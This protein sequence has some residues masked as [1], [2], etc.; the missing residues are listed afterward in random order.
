MGISLMKTTVMTIVVL[1]AAPPAMTHHAGAMYDT[2]KRVVLTGTVKDFQWTNP[3]C[4]IQLLVPPMGSEQGA[5]DEWSIQMAAPVQVLRAGWK[6]HTLNPGD[7]IVV[8][9]HPMRDGKRAGDFVAATDG[10]GKTI[11]TTLA[12]AQP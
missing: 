12:G 3:H 1:A 8:T 7:K 10:N 11:G 5:P 4:W 6:P 9:V 2:D